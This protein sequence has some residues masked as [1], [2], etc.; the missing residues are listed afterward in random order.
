M[1]IFRGW[2]WL[3]GVPGLPSNVEVDG[4]TMKKF[5]WNKIFWF[6]VLGA[7]GVRKFLPDCI[8]KPGY[9]MSSAIRAKGTSLESK[10]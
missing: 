8:T 1:E 7:G 5:V 3:V 4:A 2:Q 9:S 10:Q 6:L